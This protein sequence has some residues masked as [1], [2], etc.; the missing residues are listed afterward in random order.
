MPIYEFKCR[1]C[2]ERLDKRLEFKSREDEYP[3]CQRCKKPMKKLISKP[4]I[5][6][7]GSGFYVNDYKNK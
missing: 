6:F 7:K 5:Q 3:V 4:S 2:E 1:I